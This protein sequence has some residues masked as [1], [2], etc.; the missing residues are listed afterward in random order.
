MLNKTKKITAKHISLGGFWITLLSIFSHLKF[1]L[2]D[3]PSV[4]LA[5]LGLVMMLVIAPTITLIAKKN[6]AINRKKSEKKDI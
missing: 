3:K 4:N 6:E 5:I 2:P 1:N